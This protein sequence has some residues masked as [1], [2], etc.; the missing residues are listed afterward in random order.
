MDLSLRIL[1]KYRN[2]GLLYSQVHPT[3]PLTIWNYTE[4]VQYEGL[5]D[6]ITLSCRGLVTDDRAVVFARPFKKFFNIEEGR[7]TPTSDFEVFEK[8][9]GSL[10]IMFKYDDEVICATR[11]SFASDQAVWMSKFAKEYNYQDIIVDGFTYLFEII[12][13]ENRIVVNYGDQE[14]LVL[15]GIIKTES[16]EELHYDDISFAGWDIVKKYDGIRD[17][18]ELKSKIDNNDEGFVVRFSNGDRMK[19]KGEEY[20]RLHKVM[21]NLSTTAVWEVLSN[22]GSMDDLLK[23]V[24]DEFYGKVKEYEKSLIVQFNQLEEEYQNHFD[25]I[26]GLGIRKFFAQSALMFQHPSILFAMLDGK[27]ISPII[28]KIIKPEFKKL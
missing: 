6:E 26:K 28:W 22:G 9:D 27:D 20:L 15:L 3:L 24:P 12:Y 13:P 10:G 4:K 23:D 8:M 16:G 21:T 11:G 18:S 17:Y 2:E 5:W 14:R 1:N 19:I 25:S 7:H